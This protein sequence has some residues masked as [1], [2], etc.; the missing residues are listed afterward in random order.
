MQKMLSTESN[1]TSANVLTTVRNPQLFNL[2][3][4]CILNRKKQQNLTLRNLKTST[5][6]LVNSQ[7][8]F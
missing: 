2:Q 6:K 4:Y 5:I 1:V 8:N 3:F 7:N